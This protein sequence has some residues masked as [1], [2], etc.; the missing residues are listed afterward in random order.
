[1]VAA[2]P[3]AL[4]P[5]SSAVGLEAIALA[6]GTVAGVVRQDRLARGQTGVQ[7]ARQAAPVL[8]AAAETA[9]VPLA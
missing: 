4:A 5:P 1:M 7:V 8:P 3:M 6:S 9:G 2:W